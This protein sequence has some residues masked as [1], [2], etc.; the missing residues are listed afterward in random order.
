MLHNSQLDV[1]LESWVYYK[2]GF[3]ISE[4]EHH[5]Q[6]HAKAAGAVDN[7]CCEDSPRYVQRCVIYLLGHLREVSGALVKG[8]S[9]IHARQRL[10]LTTKSSQLIMWL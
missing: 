2:D 6:N 7:H 8:S 9:L 5:G 1:L 10:R 4:A 3:D